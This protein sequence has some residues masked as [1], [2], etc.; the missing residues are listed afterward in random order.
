VLFLFFHFTNLFPVCIPFLGSMG[1][2]GA[3]GLLALS[4]PWGPQTL[5]TCSR[6][7]RLDFTTA[8]LVNGCSLALDLYLVCNFHIVRVSP[9]S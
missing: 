7:F 6:D 3:R 8:F 1:W 5:W 2:G 4:G 9:T